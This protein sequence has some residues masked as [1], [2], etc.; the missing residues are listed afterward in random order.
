MSLLLVAEIPMFSLKFKSLAWKQNKVSYIFLIV[1]VPLL[2]L[3][4]I[5]SFAAI[6]LWYIILSLGIF[7]LLLVLFLLIVFIGFAILGNILRVL[8]GIGKRTPNYQNRTYTHQKQNTYTQNQTND[9]N[10]N[11]AETSSSSSHKRS[12]SSGDRKKIFDDDEGEY[13]DY[14]E[15]K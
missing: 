3:L 8:F 15:V 4:K 2:V 5:S 12:H 6:I 10:E 1:C 14:E 7:G 13:V 9:E 11:F